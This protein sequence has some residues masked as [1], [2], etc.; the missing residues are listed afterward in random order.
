MF[1]TLAADD[2]D[3]VRLLTV[4][5]LIAVAKVLGKDCKSYILEP[6]KNLSSDK[7][8][9]VRY[10]IADKFTTLAQVVG[11]EIIKEELISTFV[12][13]L[14]DNEAEVRTAACTQLPGKRLLMCRI[15]CSN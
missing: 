13:V 12:H 1:K 7:S 5:V 6:L 2:Q 9:R 11:D 10:M 8:W 4:Q 15:Q 3:S 14:K